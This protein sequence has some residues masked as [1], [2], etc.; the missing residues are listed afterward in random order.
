MHQQKEI[1]GKESAGVVL[2]LPSIRAV[3]L[4]QEGR[5]WFPS[6]T[7]RGRE[8]RGW[9]FW[10]ARSTATHSTLDV[11]LRFNYI[12]LQPSFTLHHPH[13]SEE[14]LSKKTCYGSRCFRVLRKS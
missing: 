13:V 12:W 3:Q 14:E 4:P 9:D 5:G 1:G 11:G 8:T 6:V 2:S 7:R 10:V